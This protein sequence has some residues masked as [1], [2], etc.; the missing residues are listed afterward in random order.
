MAFPEIPRFLFDQVK[1]A[2]DRSN[3]IYEAGIGIV[4][5][6]KD[7]DRLARVRVRFPTLPGPDESW[8]APVIS[9]GAGKNRGW[10]FLPEP[11]DEVLVMFEHGDIRKPMIVGALWNGKDLPPETND[12]NNER[13]TYQSREGSRVEFDDD[14]GTITFEDG[15][16]VAKVTITTENKITFEA[17]KG[18]V[19]IQAP[20]KD[21]NVV[22]KD[23]E[24]VAQQNFNLQSGKALTIG[25][26]GKAEFRSSSMLTVQ[27]A[28]LD[29]NPGSAKQAK[30][31]KAECEDVPD[32]IGP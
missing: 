14:K 20:S 11:E 21:L 24:M 4:T 16:G 17:I 19:C 5:D 27:G 2:E 10:H 3:N 32:P 9:L 26:G 31:A 1:K 8:W 18:D 12:G 29:L 23:I 28:R 30:E 15:G 7:P 13:R 6:N 22:A 25:C